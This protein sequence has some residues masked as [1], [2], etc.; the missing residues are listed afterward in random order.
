MMAATSRLVASVSAAV[1][2]FGVGIAPA[3]DVAGATRDDAVLVVDG[4]VREV[5]RSS[6]QD[7]VDYVV[8]IEV[9]KTQADRVPRTPPRAAYPAP[10]DVVYIHVSERLDSARGQGIAGNNQPGTNGHGS[11]VPAERAQLRAYLAPAPAGGWQ[12][13]GTDWFEL[14]SRALA[15]ATETAPAPAAPESTPPPASRPETPPAGGKSALA[16]LGLTGESVS[17]KDQFA[18][19]VSSVEPGGPA[20]RAGL[21]PG[22]IVIGAN[23]KALSG[24]DQLD[25]FVRRGTVKNL[26]VLDVNTGK[27]VRVPI[28]PIVADASARTSDAPPATTR[29]DTPVAGTG[30]RESAPAGASRSLGISAEP[31]MVGQRTGMKVTRVEAGGPA[32]KAGIEIGDVIVA[33]N[34]VPVTGVEVLSSVVKKSGASL[35][36]TVRDTRTGRDL[37]VEIKFGDPGIAIPGE[38]PADPKLQTGTG[39]KLGAVT[40]LVFYDINPAAKVTE[41]EPNSPAA[42]AGI[43]PGDIIVEANGATV[44]HPKDLEDL[45]RKSAPVL[46]LIVVDPHTN[47]KTPVEV[48]LGAQ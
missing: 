46:K 10:G 25:Q 33:A 44:L 5:F 21:E 37:P 7:R 16:S 28:E 19:R 26:V 43:E 38:L 8:Q 1:L 6:R 40:E 14:T 20:Q 11:V 41:V 22:D 4:V 12:G 48:N 32:Q 45:V 23:D 29:P 36:V 9:Q 2:S 31:C 18:L 17:A 13:A 42:R 15:N 3:Q 24:L 30:N 47:K 39:H 34:G 35:T 27:A